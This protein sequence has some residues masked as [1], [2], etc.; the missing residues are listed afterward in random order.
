MAH[1]SPRPRGELSRVSVG[2]ELNLMFA[3]Q[4]SAAELH[5]GFVPMSLLT[6]VCL[7]GTFC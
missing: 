4:A 3:R 2:K 6:R 5:P 7:G 1:D